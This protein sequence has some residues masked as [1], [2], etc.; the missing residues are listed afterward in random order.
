VTLRAVIDLHCHIL[1]A[2]DDGV[3]STAES[4]ALARA[5]L[6]EGVEVIA[7]T[8]HVRLD[9]P[10][11]VAAMEAGVDAVRDALAE[12]GVAVDVVHGGELDL[13][14]LP[15]LS[16]EEIRRFSYAQGGRWVLVE[17]PEG[18]WP[19]ALEPA[20]ARLSAAGVGAVLAHPER[21]RSVQERPSVLREVVAGG[22]LV[23]LTSG[24]ILGRV[25]R[26]ARAASYELLRAGLVHVVASDAHG[27]HVRAFELAAAADALGDERLARH[28]VHDVP[29]A[30][31][32]GGHVPAAAARRRRFAFARGK[33]G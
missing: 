2:L 14:W 6:A 19:R 11:T 1:P 31:L 15:Q 22:A 17:F 12:A 20:L 3:R 26:S 13:A 23:Q 21:N 9:Y 7:A 30:I 27:P 24:S 33:N 16:E 25:G 8:P 32:A 5:A 10:T 29:A 28:L 4:V 18:G